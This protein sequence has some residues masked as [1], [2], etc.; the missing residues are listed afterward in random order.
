MFE[1]DKYEPHRRS[2]PLIASS[3]PSLPPV[4]V[5][6][7]A[8]LLWSEHC[9]ECAAPACY[10]SCDLY[11]PRPDG[12]CRRFAFG[13]GP[14]EV[15]AGPRGPGA[16]IVFGRWA[17]L[18]ARG[19]TRLIPAGR[20]PIVERAAS[21]MCR[22]LDAAGRLMA[23]V[24]RDRRWN[25]LAF[26]LFERLNAAVHR[27]GAKQRPNA[28]VVDLYNP[29]DKDVSFLLS[30]I[31]YAPPGG[32]Y[33]APEAVPAPFR[34]RLTIAPGR[35][36][37]IIPSDEFGHVTDS[38]LPFN[39][40]LTP[41]GEDGSHVVVIQLDLVRLPPSTRP[42]REQPPDRPP[43]DGR[44]IPA[45][46][47]VV[48]DLDHTLWEG[49]LLETDDVRL[50]PVVPG[51]L[52]TLDERGILLSI[53]SKNAH[54]HAMAKLREFG[55]DEYFIYPKINWGS[56]SENVKRIAKDI[57]IGLDT[58][59]FVDDNP[60]ELEEV[61][62]ALGVVECVPVG[63]LDRLLASPR[64]QGSA[65]PEART[66]RALYRTA[67]VRAE[68]QAAF[69]DDYLAFLKAS[70]IRVTIRPDRPE[71]FERVSELVQRT[72]QLNFSGHKY[73]REELLRR[74]DNPAVE[75]YVIACR[76][77]YGDYGTVGFCMASR[78]GTVV[79]IE[80]LM[81]S[82]RVQG[83][84]IEAALFG[85][86]CTT[87]HPPATRVLVNFRKTDRNVPAQHVLAKLGFAL[88]SEGPLSRDVSDGTFA[89][90]C[91]TIEAS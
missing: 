57:D 44:K 81:L 25:Y 26:A 5:E 46:K 52:K 12:R 55:L 36:R 23:P 4:E 56:K 14:N 79:R 88:E 77:R 54:D 74:F 89:V 48:F 32:R 67:M 30:M 20:L 13:M 27:L 78:D 9:I 80:D 40:A 59:V 66:R 38:G 39:I 58:F 17:K 35:F 10:S 65:S 42:A 37:Q 6:G 2:I 90:D 7:A 45:A 91:L 83:K 8:F 11:V 86:L 70:D 41:Q 49:T 85:F 63:E 24:A 71:D 43:K 3:G 76:D 1:F 22:V 50:R 68:A 69:G 28:F 34:K 29:G 47:C 21:V 84:Y 75:R 72:N 51:L 19:N 82:C 87:Q 60:F 64:L 53:A 16:E 61:A 62:Q 33:L 18:E 15:F 73:T 31:A